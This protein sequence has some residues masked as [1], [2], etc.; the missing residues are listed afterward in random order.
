MGEK[1]ANDPALT[2]GG[3]GVAFYSAAS[4]TSGSQT[5]G[6]EWKKNFAVPRGSQRIF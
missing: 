4:P 6:R 1:C 2:M 3:G 5:P